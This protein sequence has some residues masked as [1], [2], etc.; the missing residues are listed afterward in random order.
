[1]IY[2]YDIITDTDRTTLAL[3]WHENIIDMY[4][5][6]NNIELYGKIL[7]NMCFGDYIDRLMFQKQHGI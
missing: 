7:D 3:L 5:F 2:H 4:S 6:E 1:M